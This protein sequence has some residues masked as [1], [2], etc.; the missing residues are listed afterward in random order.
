MAD[1]NRPTLFENVVFSFM[2]LNL[3]YYLI[4]YIWIT[5]TT[6]NLGN[7]LFCMSS[8]LLFLYLGRKRVLDNR[9]ILFAT[10]LLT[11]SGIAYYYN[12]QDVVLQRFDSYD[13][14]SY[15]NNASAVFLFLLPVLFFIKKDYIR[16]S[17]LFICLFFIVSSVK[18]GNILASMVPLMLLIWFSIRKS[19]GS[20]LKTS[21]IFVAFVFLFYYLREWILNNDYFLRKYEQTLEGYS[22]NRDIIYAEALN[23]W[24]NAGDFFT[25]LFGYGYDGTLQNMATGYRAHNDWLELLVDYGLLGVFFYLFIFISFVRQIKHISSVQSKLSLISVLLIWFMKSCYSMGYTDEYLALLA[26]PLGCALSDSTVYNNETDSLHCQ[27]S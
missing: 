24:Y 3:I 6:T 22:S 18:R 5:P 10:I 2:G 12:Y 13:V 14:D 9:F 26:L 11:I 23:L 25:M 15:T 1:D 17:L 20:I 8:F 27:K 21:L 19:K 7:T 4:S 16:Y